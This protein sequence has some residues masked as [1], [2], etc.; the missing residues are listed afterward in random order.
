MERPIINM[1]PINERGF[2]I[3]GYVEQCFVFDGWDVAI[4]QRSMGS[5]CACFAKG[6][7]VE[8]W[9]GSPDG[10]SSDVQI[11]SLRCIN[12]EQARHI[13]ENHKKVWGI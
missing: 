3:Q 2:D 1:R 4:P 8:M 6:N 12:D 10:D 11:F 5:L 9:F 13:C 7:M